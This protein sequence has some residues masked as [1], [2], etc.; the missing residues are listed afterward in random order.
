L[1]QNRQPFASS[2]YEIVKDPVHGYIKLYDHERQIINTQAFQRLRRIKQTYSAHYV[3]PGAT[4]TR[5]SHSLGVMHVS[6]M[7]VNTL[8]EPLIH[9]KEITIQ[10]A[11]RYLFL[12]RLW[13][14]THDI[15]HGPFSHTFDDAILE[16]LGRDHE[17]MSFKILD[18]DQEL[19]D[20]FE[21]RITKDFDIKVHDVAELMTKSR[22]EWEPKKR[23][24]KSAH[25]DSAFY[26]ILL[27][28]YSSDIIDYLLRDSLFTGAGYGSFDWERLL[29]CS[30]LYKNTV[31]LDKK[32]ED[33]LYAFLLARLFMFDTVYYHRTSR[34]FD[35]IVETFLKKTREKIDYK[36]LVQDVRSYIQLDEESI[37]HD[38]RVCDIEECNNLMQRTNPYRL[39]FPEKKIT[40]SRDQPGRGIAELALKSRKFLDSQVEEKLRD[41][42]IPREAYFIDT[43]SLPLNP[44]LQNDEICFIDTSE[45][46]P[47]VNRQLIHDAF[48]M[49][50]P[51]Q[52]FIVRL[53][54][55]KSHLRFANKI[56]R[57]F[58]EVV[59]G[60]ATRSPFF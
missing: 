12:V 24:G 6:G 53:Y 49:K 2:N 32:A 13:G 3:Y 36:N 51:H 33:C 15:G 38:P 11:Q 42:N 37:L 56:K 27:G 8:L 28:T 58:K 35:K 20:V 22:E 34:A 29:Y 30:R 1:R 47:K 44:M 41:R 10:E 45:G 14:L 59:E 16:E 57:G 9:N 43:S 52:V 25:Y 4:H 40:L 18:E 39:I 48:W 7:F 21:K 23:L 17:S 55:R 50:M 19:S 46:K 26:H 54:V 60:T 31:A 5:F